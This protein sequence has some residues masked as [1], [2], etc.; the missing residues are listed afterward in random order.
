MARSWAIAPASVGS[1]SSACSAAASVARTSRRCAALISSCSRPTALSTTGSTKWRNASAASPRSTTSSPLSEPTRRARSVSQKAR[2]AASAGPL[3]IIAGSGALPR[4]LVEN[5][6]AA[7]RP[8]FVLALQGEADDA[9]VADV[10]HA[11]CRIGAAARVLDLLHAN[12]VT[13]LVLAGGV[14]RPS[15]SALLPDWR[16]AK[17]FA[18]VGYRALG[19]DGLLSA[20][21]KELEREGFRVVGADQLLDEAALPEGPLGAVRPDTDALGDIALGLRLARA[22]GALDIGQAVVVQ[23]GL[24]L[25]VEAIEGTDGLLRR[26]AGLR[27]DGPGGVLVKTEKPGQEKRADRPTIGP[28]TVVLAA[29]SGLSGIAAEAGATIVLDRAEVMRRADTA[30]LFVFGAS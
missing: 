19:D 13:D 27:R 21:V 23:Q 25:G 10:P 1:T 2:M 17:F 16:A 11:W 18:R 9:T 12:S 28:Q 14:R 15:L 29:E 22:I 5:C 20:I 7:G 8:V 24:V 6:R 4:R 3:G 30:G 26:V